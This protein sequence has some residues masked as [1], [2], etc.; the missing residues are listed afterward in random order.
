MT[1]TFPF[2]NTSVSYRD[3]GTGQAV[4]L[5]HGFGEDSHIFDQQIEY[6]QEHCRLLVPDLP[7]SGQSVPVWQ[8][9]DN[10]VPKYTPA[11][12]ASMEFMADTLAQVL[13][14]AGA[15]DTI[16]LG[17]SMGGYIT[18]AFAEKYPGL[19]KAFGLLHSTAFADTGEKKENRRQ[20]I[21]KIT[22]EGPFAFIQTAVPV[23]FGDRYKAEHP[24][25]VEQLVQSGK[26]FTAQALTA[27]YN[28]MI[29]R[30]DRTHVLSGSKLPVLFVFGTVDKAIAMDD[31]L[32]QVHLPEVSYFHA[33][34]E[35]GHVGMWEATAEMNLFILKFIND[36]G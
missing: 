19:L 34:E 4:M 29:E 35:V 10:S 14:H 11:F 22:D 31:V 6:L 30:P 9:E 16:L 27:Y 8:P 17:H 3:Q 13:Q 33:L 20:G 18:L 23:L 1:K 25:L 24:E 2:H 26:Q 36:I 28:A 5:V 7:G 32:K 21:K 12:D 15:S